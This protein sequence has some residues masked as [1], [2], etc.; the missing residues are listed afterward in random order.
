MASAPEQVVGQI[1][2][3]LKEVCDQHIKEIEESFQRRIFEIETHIRHRDQRIENL[4]ELLKMRD[5]AVVS[6]TASLKECHNTMDQLQNDKKLMQKENQQ[7]QQKIVELEQHPEA[8]TCGLPD[9]TRAALDVVCKRD[10]DHRIAKQRNE[11]ANLKA[12]CSKFARDMQKKDLEIGRLK[13]GF[14]VSARCVLDGCTR[15]GYRYCT[16]TTK[17]LEQMDY[18][19]TLHE[20]IDELADNLIR[21]RNKLCPHFELGL[22]EVWPGCLMLDRSICRTRLLMK[23]MRAKR[24]TKWGRPQKTIDP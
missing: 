13:L 3:A 15:T 2:D 11:I 23:N 8:L 17:Q 10:F 1:A 21:I 16:W 14:D 4:Q 22:T 5:A 19:W 20:F 24:M 7:L 6:L 12:K 9:L 18:E